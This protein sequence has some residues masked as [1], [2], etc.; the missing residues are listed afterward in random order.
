MS[1]LTSFV[2]SL[3]CQGGCIAE[4]SDAAG[5]DGPGDRR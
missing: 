2:T 5:D 1:L 3:K 4:D